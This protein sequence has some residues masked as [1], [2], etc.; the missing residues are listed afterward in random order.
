MIRRRA[1]VAVYAPDNSLRL[2]VEVKARPE[3]SPQ[4]AARLLR[5]M[6][7][8]EAAPLAPYFMLVLPDAI[9]L[10]NLQGLRSRPGL[11]LL[12]EG[13]APDHEAS[14]GSTLGPYLHGGGR[15]LAEI[16]EDEL[17]LVVASW[18]T[19]LTNSDALEEGTGS[20]AGWLLESGLYDVIKGGDVATEVVVP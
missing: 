14:A 19:D 10:W 3:A 4:W 13:I 7:V 18:L 20:D 12:E 15:A 5:N 1:D 9:Y 2:E 16:G 6:I 17:E 8:H 11:P